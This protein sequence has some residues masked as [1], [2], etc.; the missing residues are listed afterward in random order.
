[1]KKVSLEEKEIFNPE[2]AITFYGLSR[3]KFYRFLEQDKELPFLAKYKNRKLIL[4]Q[5]FETFLKQ[6]PE[7]IAHL[8]N[9]P[10]QVLTERR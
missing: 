6:R 5:E 10:R 8:R 4:R 1:M 3:R 2:E 7:V 9:R